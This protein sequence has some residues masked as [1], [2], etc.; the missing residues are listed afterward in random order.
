VRCATERYRSVG[1][2][3]KD[4]TF[5]SHSPPMRLLAQQLRL[6]V[7]DLSPNIVRLMGRP[8]DAKA[9]A[10]TSPGTSV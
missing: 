4:T 8:F 6:A 10:M 7:P 2:V 1:A 5:G 9:R 3:A